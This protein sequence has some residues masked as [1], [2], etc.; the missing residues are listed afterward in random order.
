ML[1]TL[2]KALNNEPQTQVSVVIFNPG[3]LEQK[4]RELAIPV[5]IID[6]SRHHLFSLINQ[7]NRIIDEIAPDVIHSHRMK[8]NIVGSISAWQQGR[9]P[10]LQTLHGK[11]EH[12]APLYQLHKH[13]KPF[14]DWFVARYYQRYIIAVSPELS[15][16]LTQ[17]FPDKKIKTIENGIDIEAIIA[18]GGPA[19]QAENAST[20]HFAIAGRLMPVKRVD[21]FIQAAALLHEQ[22][23]EVNAHFHIFGDGPLLEELQLL[24]KNEATEARIHFEGHCNNIPQ[25]LSQMHALLMTSD[26]EGLPMVLLEAMCLHTPIIAHAVGGIPHLLEHG[27]CGTLVTEHHAQGFADAIKQ[28]IRQPEHSR[29][30]AEKAFQR[31]H[32]HYSATQTART[33]LSTY[34]QMLTG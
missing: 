26:H 11:Y 3:V 32:E 27:Q 31:V 23:P 8:E 2:A 4:L 25:K 18:A 29:K 10:C 28:L 22:Q 19:G 15:D 13:I 30:M 7:L 34:Q 5:Y 9:I 21:L 24:A 33:Y 16:E 20:Y 12:R 1:L 17:Y 14:L 6:E